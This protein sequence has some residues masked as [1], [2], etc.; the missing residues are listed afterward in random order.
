MSNLARKLNKASKKQAQA[1]QLAGL[2]SQLT[3]GLQALQGK[4]AELSEISP[5]IENVQEEWEQVIYNLRA[6]MAE[7]KARVDQNRSV[8]LVLIHEMAGQTNLS[9]EA[10]LERAKQLDEDYARVVKTENGT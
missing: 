3:P 6:E 1:S 10:F 2:L 7:I 4:V 9:M 8:L 5:G